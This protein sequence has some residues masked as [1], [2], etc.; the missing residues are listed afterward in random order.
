[1]CNAEQHLEDCP[2]MSVQCPLGCVYLAGE[3][4]GEMVKVKKKILAVHLKDSCPMRKLEC[5]FCGDKSVKANEMNSHLENCEYFPIP[6]PN[7]CGLDLESTGEITRKHVNYHLAFECPMQEIECPY[8]EYGCKERVERRHMNKHEIDFTH[9][10]FRVT[11]IGM[12]KIIEK[13]AERIETLETAITSLLPSWKFVWTI[14]G[15][16]EKIRI[17]ENSFSKP[18]NVGLYKCQVQINWEAAKGHLG[19]YICVMKG[20]FDDKLVWPFKY[21]YKI[22]LFNQNENGNNRTWSE[23]ITK[24]QLEK[25][26]SSFQKPTQLRNK[27]FG[28]ASY[29]SQALILKDIYCRNDCISMGIEVEWLTW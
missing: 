11:M 23:E 12:K 8:S 15:I 29:I 20:D 21:K 5:D 27:G 14:T 9:Q 16:S 4:K 7:N 24:S 10:H 19:C 6:C 18:F 22:V 17:K 1:M 2:E 25:Y 3:E 13:Q 28:V 26:S